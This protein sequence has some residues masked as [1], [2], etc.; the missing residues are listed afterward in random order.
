MVVLSCAFTIMAQITKAVAF[1][2]QPASKLQ[3]L[4]FVPNLWQFGIDV[5]L[6]GVSYAS[7]QLM[8][9]ALLFA[10]YGSNVLKF[11]IQ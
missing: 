2:Y 8:G 3:N 5:V 10:F 9:F 7:L 11:Y 6:V 1:K 4:A